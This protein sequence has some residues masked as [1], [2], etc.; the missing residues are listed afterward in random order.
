MMSPIPLPRDFEWGF[1][2][3][4]YQVEGAVDDDGRGKSIWDTFC[5]L[6]PTRTKGA[7]GDI[8]CDHYH[9]FQ[10]DFDLLSRY[11]AKSYR[12]SISWSRI[13][14]LGGRNDPLNESGI[15]FYNRLI[16]SLLVRGIVPWVTLYHWD[17][18]QALHDRYGGW[19]DVEESQLDFERYAKVCY[20]RFGDRVKNWITLNEPWIVSIFGYATGGNAPGRSSINPQS[21]EGDTATE[22][23]IVGKSLIMSHARAVALYNREFRAIQR[24]KIGISLNGDYYEPW[25]SQDERDKLAAERRMEFHIGWFANPVC[26]AQDYPTCMRE[27]LGERLPKF[28]QAEMDLLQQA[29]MDFYGMNYYTSQ[30]A[31]HRDEPAPEN[32]FLGNVEE[33]Q[34]DKQ[35]V[36]V[37]EQSGVHWLRSTP[38]LFR[39]HLTRVYQ[40]YGKPIYIT[41]N[42]CPCPG[43]D[44]MTCEEAVEDNYRV[45]YFRD[46]IDAVGLACNE[47]GSDIRGYFAWSLMDN[48]G[49]SHLETIAAPSELSLL[50]WSDGYGVRFGVTFTDY[51]TLVRTPKKSALQLK[52][53][54]DERIGALFFQYLFPLIPLVHEPSLRDGLNFFVT[55][56]DNT[57]ANRLTY[58]LNSLKYPE[59]WPD[60]TFTLIT[61][62]CA[63]AAFLLPKNIFPEGESIAEIFLEASRNCLI[64]YLESDLEYPNANSV[65]IR[66]FHSNCMHAAGKP[67]L[68]WHIFGEA[69]R[70]AQVMQMHE[71]ESLQG[72]SPL[73]AEFRR[74]AFWIVYIGD[75]SAA[76]LNNRPITIHKFSFNSGIT[77]G[78]PTGIEDETVLTPRSADADEMTTRKSFIAGFNANIRLWESASDLL[79]EMRLIDQSKI[80]NGVARSAPTAE[81]RYRLDH[82]FVLFATSLDNLPSLLQSDKLVMNFGEESSRLS[83]LMRQCGIQAANLY[84]SLHCLKMVITQKLEEFN[85]YPSTRND[86]LLLRK[87]DIARDM[88][89]VICDAPFWT[90]QVNGEPCV[91]LLPHP[92]WGRILIIEQVEKIRLIGASLLEII[93]QHESSPLSVR[94]RNDLSVLLDILTRLDSKASDTLRRLL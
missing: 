59:L 91:S 58:G 8:A 64:T 61:A 52:S 39:K 85:H 30:F 66:Y 18:P 51:D 75:K 20:E 74:R 79:L 62:V 45:R 48:L 84:V 43:E 55:R 72:L 22:P 27:Q 71:E 69:T 88:L 83:G 5:H 37:G 17:L 28:T 78:Y 16:D 24:G 11:G 31:R 93:D 6:E 73:E 35:G 53:M 12:F 26:L 38:S 57:T 23:W 54:F 7:N 47:D 42:G 41:E 77:I 33:F 36:S 63:E 44:K 3:A 70:L 89:R 19:L 82:L 25:D 9:R 34:E 14:P 92:P 32:D 80:V 90:L 94:A 50:E 21:T 65:A 10:E 15:E 2:T 87:T 56:R 4:A 1:A 86:I 68:S 29:D 40:K 13:I 60:V 81:E 76:I 49:K 46:H 67:R